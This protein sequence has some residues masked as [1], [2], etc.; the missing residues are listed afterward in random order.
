MLRSKL[1]YIYTLL[2]LF[3]SSTFSKIY[4]QQSSSLFE[5][6]S[7]RISLLTCSP[8]KEVYALYGHTAIRVQNLQ[9]GI[10][11][12]YN[13]G[14]FD[15]NSKNFIW[16]FA[17]GETDYYLGKAPYKA[18]EAAYIERGSYIIEQTLN[19]TRE[20]ALRL[21]SNL[22]DTLYSPNSVYRY[23]YFYK[24]CSSMARDQI[25]QAIRGTITYT[26]TDTE[27]Q[28]FRSIIHRYTASTPW[29]E[30]GQD[31]LLG[32]GADT[33]ISLYL[34]QFAPE[35]LQSSFATA[36]I[37]A[38]NGG[39]R[40]LVNATTV[41]GKVTIPPTPSMGLL[42]WH[43]AVLLLCITLCIIVYDLK[44]R[45]LT[46]LWDI[47]L[48]LLQGIPG[49]LVAFMVLCSEHPTVNTN[50]IL[51]ICNPLPLFYLPRYIKLS[52]QRKYTHYHSISAILAI[53]LLGV[54]TIGYQ[55][56]NIAV[57][58]FACNLLL[59]HIARYHQLHNASKT[60]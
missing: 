40:T 57:V 16:R 2:L 29:N 9:Q 8:G 53:S 52:K 30:F 47:S 7:L 24:N 37:I 43:I 34:Q 58:L 19:L 48:M 20:E 4:A 26:P 21:W 35:L 49:L 59:L 23:N 41:I 39:S 54:A 44:Q 22:N 28:S 5:D 60:L 18:F 51:L 3:I 32:Y 31:L 10:D 33:T 55:S 14:L 13:Y 45:H 15:F 6:D 11:E 1:L 36:T 56:I 50:F 38:P 17:L 42:P 46:W 12:V 25:I 27:E